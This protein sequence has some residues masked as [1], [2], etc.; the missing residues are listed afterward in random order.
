M[1]V[2]IRPYQQAGVD[3][4]V[5]KR[6]ALLGDDMRLGK[7]MQAILAA[8]VVGAQDV[9]V[10]CPAIAVPHWRREL[11]RW[12]PERTAK[13]I[14]WFVCSYDRARGSERDY[15]LG[16]KWDLVIVDECHFAKNPE[17]KRTK[18]I[19]GKEGLGWRAE[20]MW[21]LSGTPAPKH[22]GELWCMLRAFGAVG[23]TYAEFVNRYCTVNDF[24]GRITGTNVARIPEL[25]QILA[26]VMLRR[27]RKQVAPDMPD[28]GFNFLE[29]KP[30]SASGYAIPAGLDDDQLLEWV[31]AHAVVDTKDRQ[32]VALAKV[33]ALVEEIVFAIEN[34]LLAQ[35][36]VFGWHVAPLQELVRTLTANSIRAALI[37]GATPARERERV[38]TDFREGRL[39]VVGANILAAGTATDMSAARHGY[40]LELCWVPGVNVQAANR[41]VSME[42]DD[43][44]T[45]DVCT[46]PGSTDDRVQQVLVKRM[47]QL[48]EMGLA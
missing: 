26:G 44:V 35:T 11:E 28:I 31:E 7:S 43:P 25:K 9:I 42:K 45:F 15:I 33:P 12:W 36:V 14:G 38:L 46:W 27:T 8:E 39:Q 2:A 3:F 5:S 13:N 48:K 30:A 10:V 47:A 21:V 24:T 23:M 6:H 4:L 40:F 20:R 41:L 34:G 19:Y 22:A 18:L 17:A 1:A 16:L 29:V 37:T 32:E